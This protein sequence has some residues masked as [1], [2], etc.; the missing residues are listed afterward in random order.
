MLDN[1]LLLFAIQYV[2]FTVLYCISVK[3]EG[4]IFKLLT[5]DLKN[6]LIST[7]AE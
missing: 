3:F 7:F 6:H 2:M 4:A 5:I 1:H